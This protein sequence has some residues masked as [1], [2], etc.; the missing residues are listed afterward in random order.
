MAGSR[1]FVNESGEVIL[2]LREDS[3]EGDNDCLMSVRQRTV[4][5][6]GVGHTV[7]LFTFDV[8]NGEPFLG[9]S[10]SVLIDEG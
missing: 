1:E 8:L 5:R 7:S 2:L 10:P 9:F 4:T 6:C 3:A